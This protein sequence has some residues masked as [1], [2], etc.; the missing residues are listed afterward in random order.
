MR[1]EIDRAVAVATPRSS[2]ND[3]T[4]Y[5]RSQ[6]ITIMIASIQRILFATDF[7]APA[8]QAQ[9]YAIAL[10][11]KFGAELHVLHAVAE[12]VF[13]PAPDLAVQ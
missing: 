2:Y 9:A 8:R 7:S 11:E 1:V 5:L 12:D 6:R 13:I 4:N 3:L 10:A